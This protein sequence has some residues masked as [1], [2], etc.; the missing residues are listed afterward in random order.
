MTVKLEDTAYFHFGTSDPSTG[1]ATDADSLP[2]VTIEEDG[3][4]MGYAPTVTNVAVGLYRV[5][6]AAT[7]ANGFEAGK[8]YSGYAVATVSTKTGR[9]GIF[10]FEC[11]SRSQNDLALEAG[12]NVADIKAK[13]DN[14]PADPADESLLEAAIATRAAAGEAMALT[15]AAVDAV[16]DEVVEGTITFR[17]YLRLFAAA[18]FSRSSGGG[19]ATIVFRDRANT[20]DRITATVDVDGN[21][22]AVTVD[23]T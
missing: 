3:V 22:T 20:K 13:T 10:E 5:T 6:V 15:G 7:A 21:R 2:T 4:A 12:G 14:L 19:T 23:G 11:V 8:R 16:L 1:A 17:E 18:L 9:D